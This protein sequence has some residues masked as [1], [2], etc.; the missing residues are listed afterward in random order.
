GICVN[1]AEPERGVAHFCEHPRLVG[2]VDRAVVVVSHDVDSRSR[3][4]LQIYKARRKGCQD[5]LKQNLAEDL[6]DAGA[7]TIQVDDVIQSSSIELE[8]S[9][10]LIQQ[11]PSAAHGESIGT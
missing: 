3:R 8:K 4:T 7:P 1:V 10:G 6:N 2:G 11:T 9:F 5:F